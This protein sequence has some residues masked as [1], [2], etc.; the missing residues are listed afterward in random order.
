MGANKINKRPMIMIIVPV[1]TS[2]TSSF[3]FLI[4][5]EHTHTS[6][7]YYM[8]MTMSNNIFP[9]KFIE[10]NLFFQDYSNRQLINFFR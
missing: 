10:H 9:S 6:I 8:L 5:H 1:L 2:S 3:C 4:I 7:L